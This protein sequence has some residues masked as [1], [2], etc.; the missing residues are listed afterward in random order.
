[1]NSDLNYIL[2]NVYC[3][4]EYSL[5]SLAKEAESADY[6]AYTYRLNTLSVKFRTAKRTPTK[7]GQFV[8]LWKRN[9]E[10]TTQPHDIF[11][12]IDLVVISVRDNQ[13]FGQFVFPKSALAKHGVFSTP[14][15]EGK[16]GFRVYPPWDQT[17]NKQAEKTQKWQLDFFL[18]LNFKIPLNVEQVKKL[19]Q[20]F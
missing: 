8:T 15:K 19:Y 6:S 13:N 4:C 2:E 7:I 9:A 3:K 20:K 11:D 10:G 12:P 14:T 17:N 18:D 1:M 5:S 16:R